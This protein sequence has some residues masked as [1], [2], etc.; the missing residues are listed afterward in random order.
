MS[1][2]SGVVEGHILL[3][4]R[5]AEQHVEE[6]P[7]LE[8]RRLH[9]KPDPHLEQPGLKLANALHLAQNIAEHC[10]VRNGCERG[11]NALFDRDGLRAGLD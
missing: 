1:G 10:F 9:G 5:I 4:R 7:S 3:H 2:I 6:L 8:A 11:L